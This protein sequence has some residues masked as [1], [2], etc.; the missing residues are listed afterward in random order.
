M[1][2]TSPHRT[3]TL[4]RSDAPLASPEMGLREIQE[5]PLPRHFRSKKCGQKATQRQIS[6]QSNQNLR[7][8]SFCHSARSDAGSKFAGIVAKW[9]SARTGYGSAAAAA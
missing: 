6:I 3:D 8:I 1:A 4:G 5:S 9:Q 2:F 7:S